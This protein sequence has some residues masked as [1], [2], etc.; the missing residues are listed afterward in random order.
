VFQVP[1]ATMNDSGG[2]ARGSRSEISLF[3]EKRTSSRASALSRDRNSVDAAA[4]HDQLKLPGFQG[5]PGRVE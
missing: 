3:D 2:T 1:Q 4:D 5:G